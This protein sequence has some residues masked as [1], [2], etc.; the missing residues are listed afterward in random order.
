MKLILATVL[1][2]VAL[3]QAGVVLHTNETVLVQS[4]T[5][6]QAS[7]PGFNTVC[8]IRYLP[9]TN[10]YVGVG[11]GMLDN[12]PK[13]LSAS[14]NFELCFDENTLVPSFEVNN[15]AGFINGFVEKTAV[16]EEA[17][18]I[19]YVLYNNVD[20]VLPSGVQLVNYTGVV[21]LNMVTR[22]VTP[23]CA[24]EGADTMASVTTIFKPSSGNAHER[25]IFSDSN[26]GKVYETNLA[27]TVCKTIAQNAAYLPAPGNPRTGQNGIR[28]SYRH[29]G[30]F[31][32]G[33]ARPLQFAPLN[34]D[35][36]LGEP[37][38]L[39]TDFTYY[40]CVELE[41]SSSELS[42]TCGD[43]MTGDMYIFDVRDLDNVRVKTLVAPRTSE[44]V[45][46]VIPLRGHPLYKEKKCVARTALGFSS[47]FNPA[48]TT[49]AK[50]EIFCGINNKN[51]LN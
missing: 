46:Q 38:V 40:G 39:V 15:N 49:Y 47:I 32:V 25:V 26:N 35:G 36:S 4:W 9:A 10:C 6:P 24:P 14:G 8:Q 22:D 3:A 2:L 16:S 45:S 28:N 50:T 21:A 43:I 29:D 12:M 51:I 31:S 44:L 37:R 48:A 27:G 20:Q 11:I 7:M 17:P 13:E 5:F 41:I 42:L 19:V 33:V 34:A 23:V 18:T 1:L 30:L